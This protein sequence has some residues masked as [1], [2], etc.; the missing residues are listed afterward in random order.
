M[1]EKD[2]LTIGW[3]EAVSLPDLGIVSLQIKADTGA[4]TSALHAHNV[5]PV[6]VEGRDYVQF[7][8]DCASSDIRHRHVLP[9]HAVRSVKN[10]GG[11]IDERYSIRT[12]L[13]IGGHVH[14]IE[15]TLAD[16]TTM[17][18][19]MI[20][21]RRAMRVCGMIVDPSRSFILGKSRPPKS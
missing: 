7:G 14:M 2:R 13:S 21:G 19:D 11:R 18:Y 12:R 8:V 5:L 1:T 6:T 17:R 3:R 15:L 16:R 10:S 9:V 20:L 4:R